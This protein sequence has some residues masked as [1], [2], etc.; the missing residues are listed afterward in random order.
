MKSLQRLEISYPIYRRWIKNRSNG[1][2]SKIN[3]TVGHSSPPLYNT[4]R[5]PFHSFEVL[6]ILYSSEREKWPRK[7]IV[8]RVRE[9][10]RDIFS[11]ALWNGFKTHCSTTTQRYSFALFLFFLKIGNDFS[12]VN[13]RP[14]LGF[15][16]KVCLLISS[17]VHFCLIPIC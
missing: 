13:M 15:R 7:K 8:E 10:E 17:I 11:Q 6:L 9:R 2:N 1:H 4:K 14:F 5:Q 12:Y 3:S 16:L